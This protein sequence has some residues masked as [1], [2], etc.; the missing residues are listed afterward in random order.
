MATILIVDDN[1]V[2]RRILVKLLHCEGHRLL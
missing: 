1:P 2:D